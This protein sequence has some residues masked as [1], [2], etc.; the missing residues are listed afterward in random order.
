MVIWA[1]MTDGMWVGKITRHPGG[2]KHW[3]VKMELLHKH[4]SGVQI[5]VV[6]GIR[7][8]INATNN[9]QQHILSPNKTWQPQHLHC[10]TDKALCHFTHSSW[11]ILGRYANTQ[12]AC[13]TTE[14]E[15]ILHCTWTTIWLFSRETE[16]LLITY[17]LLQC[18]PLRVKQWL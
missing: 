10:H 7:R 17:I 8:V 15:H 4:E 2:V 13:N 11:H 5:M 14:S 12:P 16:I 6:S 1:D 9:K 3:L 18:M